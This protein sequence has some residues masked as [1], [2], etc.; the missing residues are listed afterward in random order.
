VVD[1]EGE[2]NRDPMAF[3]LEQRAGDELG[4]RLLEIEVVE[5]K[6]EGGARA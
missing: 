6:V 1:V 4:G 2:P 3:G 5:S